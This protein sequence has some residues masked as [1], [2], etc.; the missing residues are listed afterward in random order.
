MKKLILI[1]AVFL[2]LMIPARLLSIQAG[3]ERE[4][5]RLTFTKEIAVLY[6][7]MTGDGTRIIYMGE[8]TRDDKVIRSVR[9]WDTRSGKE[10]VLFEDGSTKIP[11]SFSDINLV[12]GS[13]PPLLSQDGRT[14]VFS[15][16]SSGPEMTLDHYLAVV[17]TDNIKYDIYS[18]S[19][20]A[21]EEIEWKKLEFQNTQWDRIAAYG[22]SGDGK[23]VACVLKGHIGPTRY[24]TPS[25][26]VFLDTANKTKRF[27]LAPQFDK[28]SWVWKTFPGYPLTGGG[29]SFCLSGNG[30]KVVFGARSSED[31]LD[32]DLYIADTSNGKVARLTDFHD[33][34]FS[35]A[36]ISFD[37]GRVVFYYSGG[38]KMGQGTYVLNGDGSD[39]RYLTTKAG[40]PIEFYDMSVDGQYILFKDVY[41]GILMNLE[42][43]E[44]ITAFD[45]NTQGYVS[46][47]I[48]MD[49]PKIPSFWTPVICSRNAGRILLSGTPTENSHSEVYILLLTRRGHAGK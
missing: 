11:E 44:K 37:A 41:A 38:K 27:L 6:P 49:F 4:I 30:Q 43:G 1:P 24:G 47:I 21:L 12:V 9:L 20:P 22:I 7:G 5:S 18:F 26:I 35:L 16:S 14:A 25:A 2:I 8:K 19:I 28:N 39:L 48:P 10:T 15:L 45:E 33:R 29:W 46:G 17:S 13:K 42:T 32:Y 31:P 23:T 36:D 40:T 3:I 34:W